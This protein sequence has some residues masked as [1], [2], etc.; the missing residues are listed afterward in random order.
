MATNPYTQ[1]DVNDLWAQNYGKTAKTQQDAQTIRDQGIE[2]GRTR[3]IGAD[4]IGGMLTTAEQKYY[5][6]NNGANNWAPKADATPTPATGTP[7]AWNNGNAA[8]ADQ[9]QVAKD[10]AKGK[11]GAEIAAKGKEMGLTTDQFGS[12]FGYSG[13]E[14]AG[15]GYGSASGQIGRASC[16]ERV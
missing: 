6:E 5:N 15:T 16:R 8:T 9:L 10:W 1:A 7:G 12:V 3:G 13:A 2:I 4:E 11:T 14:A